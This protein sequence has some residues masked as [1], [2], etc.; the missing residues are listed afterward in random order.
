[1]IREYRTICDLSEHFFTAGKIQDVFCGELGEILLPNGETRSFQVLEI[2]GDT[3]LAAL[4]STPIGVGTDTCKVRF[5]GYGLELSLSEDLLGR[6][7]SSFGEALDGGPAVLPEKYA[8]VIAQ[9]INPLARER[10]GKEVQ[11][12]IPEIDKAEQLY[13]GG[14]RTIL[15][16]PD[17]SIVE[18][19]T[20]IARQVKISNEERSPFTIVIAATALSFAK[21]E[22][23]K[24][25][26]RRCGLTAQTVLFASSPEDRPI[27]HL[28]AP[29]TAMRAAEYFAFEKERHVLFIAA[30]WAAYAEAFAQAMQ[31]VSI[32]TWET[33]GRAGNPP[34][35]PYADFAAL[36]ER[37][38][39]RKG[40]GG[41]ITMLSIL[42]ED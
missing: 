36:E 23:L 2:V 9:P 4:F 18:T 31:S 17:S 20:R 1:M 13:L 27:L 22:H 38:G 34:S 37:V 14:R 8:S 10:S 21:R 30:D 24:A 41:S 28:A 29:Y 39:C 35:Y 33:P 25:E 11:I 7:W 12:D 15:S 42:A 6:T 32:A 26:L 16:D 3:V 40:C 19:V 5:F